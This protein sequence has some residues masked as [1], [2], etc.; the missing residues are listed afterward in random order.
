MEKPNDFNLPVP[1]GKKMQLMGWDTLEAIYRNFRTQGIF[2]YEAYPGYLAKNTKMERRKSWS[3]TGRGFDSFYFQV[4]DA[5]GGIA[6]DMNNIS[7]RS[8]RI[9]FYYAMYLNFVDMGVGKGRPIEK[10][11]RTLTADHN[12]RYM[13]W[14]AKDGSTQRPAIA[15]EFRHQ[16]RR[17]TSYFANR[18]KYEAQIGIINAFEEE[19]PK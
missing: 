7:V 18:Y 14:D 17:L 3:S 4:V 10:V 15:M 19:L 2:P 5:A 8:A 16:V 12:V 9:D 11:N 1:V 13:A 6:N